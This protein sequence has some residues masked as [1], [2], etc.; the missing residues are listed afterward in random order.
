MK[1][2]DVVYSFGSYYR[3]RTHVF[4]YNKREVRRIMRN[5]FGKG[6]VIHEIEEED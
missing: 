5:Q 3:E 4:A 6:V 1:V 2:Y